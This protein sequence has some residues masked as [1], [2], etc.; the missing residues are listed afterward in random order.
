MSVSDALLEA[1]GF[2]G[3]VLDT[4]G[5][6]LRT[7]A[8]G[9][10][11]L[12][13]ILDTSKRKS[14]RDVL[15]HYGVLGAN[16]D[17]LD[18]GDVAGTILE[19]LAVPTNLV[20][21]GLLK[22]VGKAN[23]LAKAS[24]ARRATLL[25]HGAM[26]EEIAKLT[27]AV[28]ESGK[29]LRLLAESKHPELSVPRGPHGGFEFQN[30]IL[31]LTERRLPVNAEHSSL[32][33]S[34]KEADARAQEARDAI[35][36]MQSK[37]GNRYFDSQSDMGRKLAH[38][39]WMAELKEGRASD[40][41]DAATLARR[42]VV[43]ES[44]HTRM[45]F[46]DTR[47]PLDLR[48]TL[49]ADTI[50]KWRD[51]AHEIGHPE[52]AQRIL[53]MPGAGGHNSAMS[54]VEA[55]RGKNPRNVYLHHVDEDP[56]EKLIGAMGHD[57]VMYKG[58]YGID[59]DPLSMNQ[60]YPPYVAPAHQHVRSVA[61]PASLLAAYNAMARAHHRPDTYDGDPFASDG[62]YAVGAR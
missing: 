18:A 3:D 58:H 2:A 59:V 8:T 44:P 29:P 48:E 10:N 32:L 36:A 1:L 31:P 23:K 42:N 9:N 54:V 53:D 12:A 57:A 56:F 6:M 35:E 39:G 11:P 15:E 28:D 47:T 20:G 34:A 24:N 4:P 43:P 30:T 26:P 52:L 25:S 33:M 50:G 45:A 55:I 38:K 49:D 41:W 13:A 21:G 22:G 61:K 5:A 27:K 40:A 19:M 37:I 46:V 51:K 16:K 7:A 17:G 14:G 62:P 60:V